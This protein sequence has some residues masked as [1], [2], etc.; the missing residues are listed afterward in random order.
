[1]ITFTEKIASS[2][3]YDQYY[4]PTL[5][6]T[7]SRAKQATGLKNG[8]ATVA[9]SIFV[10]IIASGRGKRES[11][12]K[13]SNSGIKFFIQWFIPVFFRAKGSPPCLQ[14]ARKKNVQKKRIGIG[15]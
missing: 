13:Y 8:N 15:A 1:M 6:I 11:K 3:S 10:W 2:D 12:I 14:T 7:S 5:R 9:K 4:L